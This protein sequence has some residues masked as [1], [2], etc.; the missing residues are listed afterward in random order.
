MKL[1]I[2]VGK[3]DALIN[4]IVKLMQI[5]GLEIIEVPQDDEIETRNIRRKSMT[6]RLPILQAAEGVY[7]SESLP[8][9][10][11]L[12][13]KHA[14]FHGSTQAEEA[15]VSMWTD[16][17]NQTVLPSAKRVLDMVL[18]ETM[19]DQKSFSISL[20]EFK[21]TLTSLDEHLALRN[22]L[23]GYQM[24]LADAL[25]ICTLSTAMELVLDKKTREGPLKNLW[26][27]T[28][29]I[30]KMAPV[31]RVF[32]HLIFCKDVINPNFNLEKPKAQAKPQGG[33]DKAQAKDQGKDQKKGDGKGQGKE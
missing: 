8:I 4:L 3:Q 32:G 16:Y 1:Y 13:R 5:E 20:N 17:V 19:A 33:S 14:G 24:T 2:D 29:L 18:G 26:R 9:A 28:T 12:S 21:G 11:F 30:L 31:A 15:Q 22:F 25:L 27:Y 10:R 23:V 6:G 7:I